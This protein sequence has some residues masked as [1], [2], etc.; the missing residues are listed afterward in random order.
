MIV[1]T[2]KYA[3]SSGI[4]TIDVGDRDVFSDGYLILKHRYYA[5]SHVHKDLESARVAADALR[6]RKIGSIEKQIEKLKKLKIKVVD[7]GSMK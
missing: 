2:T 3:L 1:Y 6:N 4:E 7:G 5:I